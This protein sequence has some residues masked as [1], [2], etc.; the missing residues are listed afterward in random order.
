[1]S[2]YGKMVMKA[3]NYVL[4]DKAAFQLFLTDGRIEM[5]N[6]AIE[7]CFRHIANGRRSCIPAVIRLRKIWLS[8]ILYMKVVK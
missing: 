7:R 2:A 4:D 8:C 1:M 3:V 5:H 6:I